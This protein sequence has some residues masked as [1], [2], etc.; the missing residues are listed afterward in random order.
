ML[1]WVMGYARLIHIRLLTE[2]IVI[3]RE[4]LKE[5]FASPEKRQQI[6]NN[7]RLKK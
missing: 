5:K 4:N 1:V 2:N 6:I 7:L 3:V